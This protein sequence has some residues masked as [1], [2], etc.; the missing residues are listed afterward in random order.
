MTL[1]WNHVQYK[2]ACHIQ[3]G[4]QKFELKG[5]RAVQK[6]ITSPLALLQ[7]GRS[8]YTCTLYSGKREVRNTFVPAKMLAKYER[9]LLTMIKSLTT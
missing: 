1:L 3:V 4:F 8:L 9:K 5:F 2:T 6:L 7:Q